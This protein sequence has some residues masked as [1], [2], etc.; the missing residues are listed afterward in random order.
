MEKIE[1]LLNDKLCCVKRRLLFQS[2]QRNNCTL[3]NI[4]L[5][6]LGSAVYERLY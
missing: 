5:D 2:I 4:Q 6:I 1:A 3:G